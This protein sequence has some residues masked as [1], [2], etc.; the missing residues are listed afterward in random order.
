LRHVSK[1]FSEDPLRVLRVARFAARFA[2]L[3]F[4]VAPSTSRMLQELSASGELDALVP[5]RVWQELEKALADAHPG[6]FIE[7]L[8]DCGALVK[9]WPE[10]DCLFGIPQIASYHPEI[11]TGAHL[12]MTLDIAWSMQADVEVV[13]AC[14]VHD[15][16]KGVTAKDLL[17]SHR[18]HETA[19][20]PLVNT[21]CE[22]VRAPMR[23]RKLARAVCEHHLRCH[24][25][26]E[27]K[28]GSVLR[29]IEATDGIRN[30]QH[31]EWF[32]QACEADFRGRG[33]RSAAAYPQADLLRKMLKVVKAVPAA[34][35]SESGLPGL[36]I[37]EQ[38]RKRRIEAMRQHLVKPR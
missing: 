35:L 24:R 36:Q 34:D 10:L 23:F 11:D 16:G 21:F 25:V 29:L 31:F 38:L 28:P 6:C 9:L 20:L 19:G 2:D 5:E 1:A 32:L 3:G 17:P 22:R 30:Q 18:G 7:T 33:G 14:L 8:R 37:A 27:M 13:F 26:L 12:L 15:L 4:S